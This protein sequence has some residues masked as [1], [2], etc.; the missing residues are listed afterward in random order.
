[1]PGASLRFVSHWPV[2]E[3]AC[4]KFQRR[5]TCLSPRRDAPICEELAGQPCTL[6]ICVANVTPP[7]LVAPLPDGGRV[8]TAPG[9][10]TESQVRGSLWSRFPLGLAGPPVPQGLQ[11]PVCHRPGHRPS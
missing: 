6:I 1:M 5:F 9:E 4:S 11:N 3:T 7:G 8:Q 10:P 2:L